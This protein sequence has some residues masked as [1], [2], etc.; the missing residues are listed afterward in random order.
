MSMWILLKSF[1]KKDFI[2]FKRYI[3]NSIWGIISLY[4]MF[5]LIF[6]GYKG[7]A[8]GSESYGSKLDGL[9][10]G[11]VLF[12]TVIFAYSAI[13]STISEE[14]RKGTLEQLYMS[15]FSFKTILFVK[16]ISS[17]LYELIFIS[18]ILFLNML[19]T[20]HFLNL[21][22][23]SI[24]PIVICTL[25]CFYGLGLIVGGITLVFKKAEN[26]LQ[27]LQFGIIVFIAVPVGKIPALAL[28]PGAL[29]SNMIN[30]VMTKG[31]HITEFSVQQLGLLLLVGLAYLIIGGFVY[32]IF[33]KKSMKM[34]T[35]GHY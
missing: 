11:Y 20:G 32:K 29:G 13:S 26:F 1:C 4:V 31:K 2:L 35:L 33:E 18:I 12:F 21:D 15:A 5:L 25:L 30:K 22:L 19:T 23:L 7:V 17:L 8:G 10:V 24:M 16:V 34:G 27:I 6:L 3:F 28:L 9:I 14:C